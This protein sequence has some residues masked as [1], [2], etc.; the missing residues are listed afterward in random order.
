MVNSPVKRQKVSAP[1]AAPVVSVTLPQTLAFGAKAS[2]GLPTVL[3]QLG[4]KKPLI[5][6]DSFVAGSGMLTPILDALDAAGFSHQVFSK[7]VP[8]PTTSSVGAGLA[9]W[10]S[11]AEGERCDCCV[12]FGGG[13]SID[14]AKAIALLALAPEDAK[15]RDFK[16]PNVPPAGLPIVA[17][18]TT[19]GTGSEVTRVTIITDDETNEKMLCMGFS[20]MPRAAIVDYTLT[21]SMPFRLTADSGLDSLCHAMEAY[22]SKK[23]NPFSDTH[24]LAAM[25]AIPV[26]LRA[27]CSD[28]S[29]EAG[30]EALMLAATHAGIAFSNAS[31]TLIHGMSRPIGAHFHVPH[32]LSNAML[33]PIVTE[34]SLPGAPARY[35]ECARAMGFAA[36]T[37][38]DDLSGVK[39]LDGLRDLCA[40]LRVPSPAVHGIDK[41]TYT[42]LLETMAR[43]ALASGSPNNNPV[44]PTAEQ[45]IELYKRV[46]EGGQSSPPPSA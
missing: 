16:V 41:G 28:L 39:L 37:D 12:G 31:V 7:C 14:S 25:K 27:V 3:T 19:A 10:R 36:S 43:Q 11:A 34:F 30:R 5:V 15:M 29:N 35:A 33:L 1:V 6:T 42:G 24:A 2:V 40:E 21:L 13:S 46:Y 20:L 17:I 8:D 45:I 26:N 9:A 44:I 22:V 23:A 32:G 38:D 18:P 4:L